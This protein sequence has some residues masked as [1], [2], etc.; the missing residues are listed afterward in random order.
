M[1][2]LPAIDLKD[3]R[4]V[5]LR[6]GNMAEET[7]YAEDPVAMAKHWERLGAERLHL[8][9]LNGAIEGCP[10]HMKEIAAIVKAVS[11]PVQVGG[12]I[13]SWEV[14][15]Q[16]L[17]LG[18][19]Q[20]VLGTSVLED[21]R[22]LEHACRDFPARILLGLDVKVDRVAVR[23]WTQVSLVSPESILSRMCQ[24]ALGGVV[25]TEIS[26]DGM[27]Q[28]P[29]LQALAQAVRITPVPLIASGGITSVADIQAIRALGSKIMGVIIGKALY[30]GTLDLPTAIE[31]AAW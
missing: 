5:R 31:A 7:C 16:Y 21:E 20:V 28:G 9:D 30:E 11:I 12:G 1:M 26:R 10:R 13:R 6:Q 8:V 18:V 19:H 24:Y 3:G 14:V 23:G 17:Q 29:N 15:H 27:L 2:V 25:F 22:L 4:C